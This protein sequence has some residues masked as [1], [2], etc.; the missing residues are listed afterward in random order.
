MMHM[1]EIDQ[2]LVSV[3]VE[4]QT[5][6]KASFRATGLEDFGFS[7]GDFANFGLATLGAFWRHS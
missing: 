5:H 3:V 4:I 6:L 7:C 2:P 1:P